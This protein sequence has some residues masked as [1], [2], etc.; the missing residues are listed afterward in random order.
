[1]S[2]HYTAKADCNATWWAGSVRA[3]PAA[4]SS[5]TATYNCILEVRDTA[6]FAWLFRDGVAWEGSADEEQLGKTVGSSTAP[7]PLSTAAKEHGGRLG[8][9]RRAVQ[10]IRESAWDIC[11]ESPE[12]S[13]DKVGKISVQRRQTHAG[14]VDALVFA[15]KVGASRDSRGARTG[16]FPGCAA[17]RIAYAFL[18]V[19]RCKSATGFLR[20]A[21]AR[22]SIGKRQLMQL[23][24][25]RAMAQSE[26][27]ALDA[28]N[29]SVQEALCEEADAGGTLAAKA[30]AFAAAIT[31]YK[32][33]T[34]RVGVLHD[35]KTRELAGH[36]G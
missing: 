30:P 31:S 7:A 4:A 21:S 1:M 9:V 23:Q 15:D 14:G 32:S 28:A 22:L 12:K 10:E 27:F 36:K 35:S 24:Q 26:T 18:P 13:S 6:V 17:L 3:K 20:I 34:A 8:C 5:S 2:T 29:D 16:L 33:K 11:A 19:R 25:H